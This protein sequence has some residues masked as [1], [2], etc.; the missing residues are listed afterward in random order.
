[1]ETELRTFLVMKCEPLNDP[2]EC[3]ADRQPICVIQESEIPNRYKT[4]GYEIYEIFS[5]ESLTIR[6]NW[7]DYD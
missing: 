6:Q 7:D 2:Y 4:F 3:D 5:N 1:M